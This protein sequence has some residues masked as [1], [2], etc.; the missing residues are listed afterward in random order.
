MFG[1]AFTS[2][3]ICSHGYCHTLAVNVPVTVGGLAVYPGDLL[4]GDLNGITRIPLDI[5]SE[6]PQVCE[7]LAAAERLSQ[8]TRTISNDLNSRSVDS[9][10]A[11]AVDELF[12]ELGF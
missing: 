9:R 5:A 12:T 6:V 3:T 1:S 2:G 10:F 8:A 11:D 7:E 4:H